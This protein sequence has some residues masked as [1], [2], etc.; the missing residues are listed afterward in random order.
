MFSL[1]ATQT[2]EGGDHQ[3]EEDE[4]RSV[5]VRKRPRLQPNNSAKRTQPQYNDTFD[6]F[7]GLF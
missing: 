4:D 7:G 6:A 1:T 5:L 2:V 3:D